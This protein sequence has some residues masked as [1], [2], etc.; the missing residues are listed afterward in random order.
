M[1][2]KGLLLRDTDN[3]LALLG[4]GV[5]V[6]YMLAK[7]GL[8]ATWGSFPEPQAVSGQENLRL[9]SKIKR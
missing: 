9:K 2:R 1:A 6:G 7:T 8:G 5:G 3:F 4:V